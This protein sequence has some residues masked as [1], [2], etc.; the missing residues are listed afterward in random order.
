[1]HA[2]KPGDLVAKSRRADQLGQQHA[3][4]I[5]AE[6]LVEVASQNELPSHS[7]HLFL[8]TAGQ[9][10]I[11]K[12]GHLQS[13]WMMWQ[14]YKHSLNGCY[15]PERVPRRTATYVIIPGQSKRGYAKLTR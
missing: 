5:E 11:H 14:P 15:S 9:I 7:R 2:R 12:S 13:N 4:I 1:M 3:R 10:R 8:L 6:R